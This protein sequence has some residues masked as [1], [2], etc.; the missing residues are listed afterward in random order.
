MQKP[1]TETFEFFKYINLISNSDERFLCKLWKIGNKQMQINLIKYTTKIITYNTQ[2]LNL[3]CNNTYLI[4]CAS[5]TTYNLTNFKDKIK[6][7]YFYVVPKA[8]FNQFHQFDL[9]APNIIH[10]RICHTVNFIDDKTLKK[11]LKI[12]PKLKTLEIINDIENNKFSDNVAKYL[13][14]KLQNLIF[15]NLNLFRYLTSNFITYLPT[16][17]VNLTLS[18]GISEIPD[19][20]ENLIHL[21]YLDLGYNR[22]KNVSKK[23]GVLQSLEIFKLEYNLIENLPGSIKMLKNLQFLNLSHNKILE[24]TK[25]FENK[26]LFVKIEYLNLSYNNCYLEKNYVNK[27]YNFPNLLAFVN[28]KILHLACNKFNNVS[29]SIGN[30]TN[31]TEL[32]LCT[33]SLHYLPKCFVNLTNLK[34]LNLSINN[35]KYIPKYITTKFTNLVDLTMAN[36]SIEKIPKTIG[37]LKKLKYL[38]LSCNKINKIPQEIKQLTNLELLLLDH[39]N[40]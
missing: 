29:E 5:N 21:K 17:L 31:L 6:Y 11:M 1:I 34:I 32:N 40:K 13:P 7:L 4:L 3:F 27:I 39:N 26:L 25:I 10:L 19:S 33:N 14:K 28:L 30:L 35:L 23:I 22:I 2:T 18:F 36:N 9:I 38:V 12:T 8:V 15:N 37:N 16:K 20:I 24:N